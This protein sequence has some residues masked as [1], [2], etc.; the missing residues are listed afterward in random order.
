MDLRER[1]RRRVGE[2][3]DAGIGM[4]EM[5]VSMVVFSVIATAVAYGLQAATNSTRQ[6][7]NRI[8]AANLAAREL[9]LARQDFN[10]TDS[11]PTDLGAASFVTNPH[12]LTGQTAGNPLTIDGLPFTVV[13]TTQWLPAGTGKSACDGGSDVTYPVL[14]VTTK[15]TWDRMGSTLPVYS[16][17]LLTPSKKLVDGNASFVAVRVLGAAGQNQQGVSVSATAGASTQ[18]VLT[19]DDGCAVFR[20][21]PS[22]YPTTYTLSAT[23]PG[24]VDPAFNA[25]ASGTA[26]ITE[27]G[28]FQQKTLNYDR[29]ATL[30]VTQT[31]NSGYT[32]PT[33]LQP[34]T[35]Y[36]SGIG[37][38]TG[39]KSFP[40]LGATTVLSGL[41]PFTSGYN[42]WV[43]SC[44]QADPGTTTGRAAAT[45]V[46]PGGNGTATVKLTPVNL[47]VKNSGGTNQSGRTVTATPLANAGCSASEQPLVLGVTNG[48]GKVTASLP[49]GSFTLGVSGTTVTGTA[50][51]P[52]GT[53]SLCGLGPASAVQTKTL[54]VSP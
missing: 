34:V 42:V 18:T 8:Q 30:T 52:S 6:D 45:V 49:A 38:A 47:T 20:L 36:N 32:L 24:Y 53:L 29:G 27:G 16:T 17:T 3:P 37:G 23:A 51:C 41:W 28:S 4:I 5:L 19:A 1:W 39:T 50:G 22:T 33:S 46:P 35:V 40:G 15:V 2:H 12:P 9:D 31:T 26:T 54:T 44:A 13:R 48:A 7:R 21:V 11:G 25:S 10:A 43:G 14:Q